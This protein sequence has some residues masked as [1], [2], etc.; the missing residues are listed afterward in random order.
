VLPVLFRRRLRLIITMDGLT[1]IV[2][3]GITTDITN[4]GTTIGTEPGLSPSMGVQGII[5]IGKRI[6]V[7]AP[8][9]PLFEIVR[10]LVRL[11]PS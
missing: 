2:T 9:S 10:V 6:I 5:A 11:G 4:T 3:E 1:D 8:R 7:R